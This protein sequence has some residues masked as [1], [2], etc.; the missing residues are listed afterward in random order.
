MILLLLIIIPNL[1]HR[2]DSFFHPNYDQLYTINPFP[3]FFFQPR[4]LVWKTKFP[5]Y[6]S[7]FLKTQHFSAFLFLSFSSFHL[8]LL[9]NTNLTPSV[10]QKLTFFF[11]LSHSK[12]H[13]K[14][15]VGQGTS[16]SETPEME[17]VKRNQKNIS[18]VLRG[19]P[20]HPHPPAS[21]PFTSLKI[22]CNTFLEL[23]WSSS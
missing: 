7:F 18:M 5:P 8:P 3:L 2:T 11:V 17:R 15:G 20:P 16:V 10:S 19:W 22:Y 23:L 21:P 4:N 9:W 6:F 13:Y 12:R 14:E 1:L